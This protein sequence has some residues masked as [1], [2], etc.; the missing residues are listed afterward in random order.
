MQAQKVGLVLSGGG[1]KGITHVGVLKALEENN[2]PIDYIAGTS[3]GAVVGGLYACGYTPEE[4]EVFLTSESVINRIK[5]DAE[6]R[7]YF[8]YRNPD[9]TASWQ[10]FSITYDS[11]LKIKLPTNA[12]SPFELDYAFLDI[13]AGASA[14]ANYNFDSLYIPFRCIASDV[15]KNKAIILRSGPVEQAIRASATF[16]F[17]FRPIKIDGKLLFDGGMYNNFPVDVM[18]KEFNPDIIIGSKAA[19][20]YGPPNEDDLV[21]Q[22]Q[23]MLMSNAEVEFDTTKNVLIQPH[24]KPINITD[25]SNN[26]SFIDSGYLATVK[27]LPEIKKKLKRTESKNERILNR[28]LF[29]K[30]VPFINIKDFK[31]SGISEKQAVFIDRLFNSKKLFEKNEAGISKTITTSAFKRDYFKLV[32]G[33]P[34]KFVY[35]R[36]FYDKPEGSY[37]LHMDISKKNDLNA[38][39]GGLVSSEAITEVF[40]QMKYTWWRKNMLQ[41]TGN[42]YLG[43][44]HSSGQIKARIDFPGRFPFFLETYYTINWWN[45]FKTSTYFF[46][47]ESPA[48]LVQRDS[49][50]KTTMGI[51]LTSMGFLGTD[52]IFGSKNDAYYQTNQFSR[53]DTADV[54][55]FDF[56]SPGLFFEIN[57]L[58]RKQ[59]ATKGLYIK[60]CLRLITGNETNSPGSTSNEKERTEH[61]HQ[62]YQIRFGIDKYFST[63]NWITFGLFGELTL[64][65]QTTFNNYT[66]TLLAAPAFVSIPESKTIFLQKYR[67]FNYAAAGAKAIFKLQTRIDLRTEGYI[68]QPIEEIVKLEDN[69][70]GFHQDLGHQYYILSGSLIFHAPFGP[71]SLSTNYYSEADQPFSLN[72]G[73]GY[74]IFNKRPY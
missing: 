52:I 12:V 8:T 69:K 38:E 33:Q 7:D 37:D 54:T 49:Y 67:A 29:N 34:V 32:N 68:F 74:F 14:A 9:Q 25:F 58:N 46:G 36:L 59:F 60:T 27:K 1:A 51:P 11:V 17:Y 62:W 10:L 23:S 64:S 72:F 21:S 44:F 41:F 48:Y 35:P 47:D 66:S 28:N 43:R 61:Y 16:P 71:I 19:S 22:V 73:I 4:I 30:K 56:V 5:G 3:M 50:L 57:T 65:N 20:E 2:I 24:L 53:V 26:K 39:I 42:M 70:A 45:Y 6:N 40:F 18:Q 15:V 13:F 63:N 55:Y 31:Y